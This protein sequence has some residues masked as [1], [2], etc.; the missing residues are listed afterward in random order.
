MGV[1]CEPTAPPEFLGQERYRVLEAIGHGGVGTVYRA[2]DRCLEVN[3]AL[4]VL[5]PRLVGSRVETRFL[6]E[7]RAMQRMRH[8]N[9]VR[10]E[11]VG[12]DG[13]YTWLAMEL[14]DRG[15]AHALTRNRNGLPIS[16]CL[17][18]ADCILAGLQAVHAAGWV[19][20]DV[21]PG[22]ILL[23]QS[24]VVKLG[25]FG[26]VRDE[27]SDL[28]SPGVTL[29]TSTYMAPEQHLDATTVTPRSDLYALGA[30]LYALATART[31]RQLAASHLR[32][33]RREDEDPYRIVPPVLRPVIQR[34]CRLDPDERYRDAG[35]MRTAIRGALRASKAS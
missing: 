19:H 16:W 15:T 17:H 26:I 31:P 12:R 32:R 33:A 24:G 29:G 35:E 1:A 14:M 6:R 27:D 20:R 34:A 21:K 3:I 18:I 7:G 30:T 8:P 13:V 4:K 10:V 28:T 22:N 5:Q 11:E 25:D 2:H 23:M 9:V